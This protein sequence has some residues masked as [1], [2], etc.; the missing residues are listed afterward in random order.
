MLQV[1]IGSLTPV[2]CSSAADRVQAQSGW[3]CL[4]D[5][6]QTLWEE[7][8]D[9]A[10]APCTGISV[11]A[12][13]QA[14]CAVTCNACPVAWDAADQLQIAFVAALALP[15]G[16]E[17]SLAAKLNVFSLDC[18]AMAQHAQRAEG[19]EPDVSAAAGVTAGNWGGS[20]SAA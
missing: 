10:Y 16:Y 17:L 12:L 18:Q 15:H 20:W 19:P 9:R 3:E 7:R 2:G 1:E 11:G 13:L 5:W 6:L 4:P 8:L 14:V